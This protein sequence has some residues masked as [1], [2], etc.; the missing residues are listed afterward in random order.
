VADINYSVNLRVDK[1]FLSNSLA[2]T[3]VTANMAEVGMKSDTY[4]LSGTPVSISTA[5]LSAAGLAFVRNL[6]TATAATCQIGIVVG[7]SFSAF[8]TPRPGEPALF[9]L[10]TGAAYQATGTA[11]TRL[12]VDITEG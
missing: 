3:N 9:R 2:A 10:A 11:G 12:R 6:A 5:N 4:A 8:A 1:D 7:T